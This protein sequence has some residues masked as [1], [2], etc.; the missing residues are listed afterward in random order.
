MKMGKQSLADLA[1]AVDSMSK[2]KHDVVVDSREM[3]LIQTGSSSFNLMGRGENLGE[4]TNHSHGQLSSRLQ[5]PKKYYDRMLQDDPDLLRHNVNRWL[6]KADTRRMVRTYRED[7]THRTVRAIMSDRYQRI[8]NYDVLEH[9][10]PVLQEEG[11]KHGLNLK[12]CEV[13]DSKLYL[14]LT[15][16][17]LRGQ[18]KAGDVVEAGVSIR[19][20][21]IGLGS[22]V[23]SPF[24]YRLWCDNGCGTDEG[25]FSRRHVGAQTQMGEQMQSYMTDETNK[26]VDHAVLLQSRDVL[27]GI[28]S[29]EVFNNTLARLQHAATGIQVEAPIQAMEVLSHSLGLSVEEN[30]SCLVNLIQDGDFSRWGVC[31]AVTKI[32]NTTE[33]YDRASELENLGGKVIDLPSSE[34]KRIAQA[35]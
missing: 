27:S 13:T 33:D 4:V 17:R 18:V 12:S 31:N 1:A 20:S 29:E 11:V 19:N 10:L 8:D 21:E 3:E 15:S 24:I 26:A 22:Y 7:D 16:P 30:Q 14:K 32:A 9:L 6:T 35:A 34:W 2:T 28:L 5:I 25:K 23:L